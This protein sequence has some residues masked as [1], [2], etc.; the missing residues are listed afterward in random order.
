M[1]HLS[2][3]GSP[4]VKLNHPDNIVQSVQLNGVDL[5]CGLIHTEPPVFDPD[6]P[7]NHF[8]VLIKI[9]A[10]SCNYRD[11]A[12]IFKAATYASEHS[13]Y[14][15]GSD[16]VADVVTTGAKV[17]GLLPG[18]R[19]INNNCY[20]DSGVAGVIPGVASNHSS[21][22]LQVFHQAKLLKIPPAMPDEVAAGFSIGAQTAYSMIR[23]LNPQPGE[24]V[25]ITAAKS[26]TS[27]FV[28]Q[29]L[30]HHNV[31]V[32]V[33]STSPRFQDELLAMGVQQLIQIDPHL[34]DWSDL[35]ELKQLYQETGG[36]HCLVDPF[37]DLHLGRLLPMLKR[38]EGGRYVTCGLYE[39]YSQYTEQN[40][41]YQGMSLNEIMLFAML[42]NVQLLGNCVGKTEDLQ[43]AVQDCADDKFTVTVD[44]VFSGTQVR[45]FLEQTYKNPKRFGKV[46]F[47]YV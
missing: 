31:N 13:F 2:I 16:F 15:I 42:N 27:L 29:A 32:Y 10:F 33:T 43:N 18:D 6:Q 4:L 17:K 24:H 26:N 37:F 8:K 34:A 9:R 23:K 36:I 35:P 14:T 12:L 40:F 28:I 47:R 44:A 21:K 3:C 7:D 19:V 30:R 20:P 1:R 41:Q 11:K 5:C 46:I 22:E 45:E 25:L 39:Q 38:G